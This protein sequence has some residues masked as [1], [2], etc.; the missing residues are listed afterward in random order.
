MRHSKRAMLWLAAAL[1]VLLAGCGKKSLEPVAFAGKVINHN[2]R[3][4]VVIFH[5]QDTE[6]KDTTP[7][8]PVD[9]KTGSFQGKALPGRYKVTLSLVRKGQVTGGP[10]GTPSPESL[11][12]QEQADLPPEFRDVSKTKLEVTIPP[13]GKQD[14]ELKLP[15]R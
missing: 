1:A 9:P 8:L 4:L 11:P 10:G 6:N 3:Q 12:G 7:S 2:E 15:A 5:P 14:I 13:E